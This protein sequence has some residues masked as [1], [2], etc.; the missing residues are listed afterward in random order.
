MLKVAS[1]IGLEVQQ[2]GNSLAVEKRELNGFEFDASDN[3]D[4]VPALEIL[5]CFADGSSQIRGVKRLVY[6]ESNRLQTLPTELVKMGAIIHAEDD[7]IKIEGNKELIGSA[8]D[9]H[10]DHRVAM[11]CAAASL[12]ARGESIIDNSE[13]VSKSYPDFFHDLTKLGAQLNVE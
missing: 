8:F 5:G 2:N 3:P 7:L 1:E 4:L 13:A 12:G 10:N 11:A 9:S 6:K